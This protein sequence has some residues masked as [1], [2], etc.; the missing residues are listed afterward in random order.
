MGY[1]DNSSNPFNPFPNN[2]SNPLTVDS[3]QLLNTTM[4]PAPQVE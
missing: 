4:G 2:V 3:L 1:V